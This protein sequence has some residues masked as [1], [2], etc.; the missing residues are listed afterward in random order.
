LKRIYIEK[1]NGKK[2]PLGIPHSKDKIVLKAMSMLLEI[3]FEPEF[4]NTSRG[5]RP[6]RGTHTA[7]ESIT[8]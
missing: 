1:S 3:F 5:F 8:K 6:N 2:R 4:L 7:L